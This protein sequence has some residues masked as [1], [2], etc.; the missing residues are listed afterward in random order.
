MQKEM[1]HIQIRFE[2][3]IISKIIVI[4]LS[5]N[6]KRAKKRCKFNVSWLICIIQTL[7][8]LTLFV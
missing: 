5:R 1:L 7:Q 2:H 6:K 4:L 3:I 8:R